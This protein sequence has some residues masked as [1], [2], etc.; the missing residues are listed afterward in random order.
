MIKKT[1]IT[2]SWKAAVILGVLMAL[3]YASSF[4]SYIFF[5]SLT[6]VVSVVIATAIFLVFWN[7]RRFLDNNYYA[8]IGFGFLSVGIID[9]VHTFAFK[10]AGIIDNGGSANMAT[11]LWLAGR[12]LIALTFLAAPFL[13]RRK[14][15][16]AVVLAVFVSATAF[17]LLSI[18]YFNIFPTAYADGAGLTPFKK[19][20]EIVIIASFLIAFVFLY[21]K[22]KDFSERVFRLLGL[23][24][25]TM[26]LSEIS[27]T[28][29]VGVYDFFNLLGHLLKIAAYYF[30]YLG[31]VEFGLMK[32]YQSL[33]KNL[34]DK[35]VKLEKAIGE[36]GLTFNSISDLIFILD[37]N[38]T[39]VRVNKALCDFLGKNEKEIIGRKCYEIM[40]KSREPW[41]KCPL[42]VTRDTRKSF[43]E[44]VDDPEIGKVLLVTTSPIIDEKG[45]I[46]G[47]VH[48]AKDITERKE[49]ERAKDE[50]TSLASHQLRTPLASISLA[51]E[52]LLRNAAGD[53][54]LEQKEML[55]EVH[56]STKRMAA[57]ISRMLNVSRIDMG[58][59]SINSKPMEIGKRIEGII[60]ELNPQM[61]KKNIT[62]SKKFDKDLPVINFDDNILQIIVENLLTNAIRYTEYGGKITVDLLRKGSQILL[63]VS[64]TGCG[65]PESAYSGIFKKSFRAENAR[66]LSSEGHGLG[67]YMVK[68]VV[69]KVGAAIRFVS[70]EGK[71]TTFFVSIPIK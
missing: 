35:E 4:H 56:Q 62:L 53:I 64:D 69:E 24:L 57:L 18:F 6:E 13:G 49:I 61:E 17:L 36:W 46:Q 20:S 25:L 52:L 23:V 32:P 38:H 45:N 59:L 37:K 51:S 5:H 8:F 30:A 54:D 12:Y 68:A 7:S 41:M 21:L 11:Q 55:N 63:S 44:E 29:Y 40:H 31:I 47:I 3:L 71:G 1:D 26:A 10:G 39:V 9:L 60:G 65:I 58:T 19:I 70:E 43:T 34:K 14:L 33:F 48:I 28:L 50:F 22:R 66:K 2:K 42:K 15:N 27:F 67:L 16:L